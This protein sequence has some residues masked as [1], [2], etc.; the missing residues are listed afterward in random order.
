MI[1]Q[2][3]VKENMR[4]VSIHMDDDNKEDICYICLDPLDGMQNGHISC[5]HYTH[6]ICMNQMIK[7]GHEKCGICDTKFVKAR[8][9]NCSHNCT[10]LALSSVLLYMFVVFVIKY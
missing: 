7:H 6:K 4:D 10:Y 9:C 5:K 2:K 3:T 1:K 8:E